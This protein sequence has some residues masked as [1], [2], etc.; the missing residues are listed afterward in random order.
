MSLETLQQFQVLIVL[1]MLGAVLGAVPLM[2]PMLIAP[3]STGR[4]RGATYECGVDTIGSAQI[5]FSVAYYLFA[6]IFI[7]FEVDVLYLLPVAVVYNSPEYH[8]RDLVEIVMFLGF[9]SLALIFAARRG[10]FAWK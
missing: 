8:L 4:K 1:V 6:I 9:L 5:R 7:A 2:I 10:V 3:R